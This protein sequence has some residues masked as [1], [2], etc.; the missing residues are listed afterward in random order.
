MLTEGDIPHSPGTGFHHVAQ[1][2]LELAIFLS[3]L[4]RMLGL[5]MCTTM[6]GWKGNFSAHPHGVGFLSE[7]DGS[8]LL[9]TISKGSLHLQH[10]IT[11]TR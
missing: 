6:S 9:G 11:C 4:P 2:G 10:H 3:Q 7:A 5:Q 8:G 1:A